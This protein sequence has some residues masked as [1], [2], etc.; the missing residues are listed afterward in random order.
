[1]LIVFHTYFIYGVFFQGLF[2]TSNINRTLVE[3][4]YRCSLS[5]EQI[6][7]KGCDVIESTLRAMS[8]NYCQLP[9]IQLL[10][11]DLSRWMRLR[12]P[13]RKHKYIDI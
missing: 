12:E 3:T 7:M 5:D 11:E 1:M 13:R 4:L 2:L 9:P 8:T 10:E 6:K